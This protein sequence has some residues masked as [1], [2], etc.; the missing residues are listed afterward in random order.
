MQ[1]D[2]HLLAAPYALDALTSDER[3]AFEAHLASCG[4]CADEVAAFRET[5][6]LL[7]GA[8]AVAPPPDLRAAVLDRLDDVPQLPL[9][10]ADPSAQPLAP[11]ISLR[12]RLRPQLAGIAAAG[13]LAVLGMVGVAVL[14]AD[15]APAPLDASFLAAAE[16]VPL[17]GAAPATFYLDADGDEGWLV[18]DG[19]PPLAAGTTYQLWLFHDDV[20]VP[21]GTLDA[22]A[23]LLRAT[24]PVRGAAVVAVTVEPAGGLDAPTGDVVLSAAL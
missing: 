17:D 13:L 5:A 23:G 12:E 7:G 19:L 20:P 3:A 22:A 14:L 15:R 2:D 8:E 16:A 9:P 1:L 10:A 11:V 21:A 24:A 4:D 18:V 6:A